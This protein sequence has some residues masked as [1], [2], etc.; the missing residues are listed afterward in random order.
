MDIPTCCWTRPISFELRDSPKPSGLSLAVLR[1]IPLKTIF[2]LWKLSRKAKQEGKETFSFSPMKDGYY[3]GISIG[4]MGAGTIGRSYRGDFIRWQLYPGKRRYQTLYANQFSIFIRNSQKTF[5]NVL[6]PNQPERNQLAA[7]KW[8]LSSNIGTYY[9]LYPRAW[10]KYERFPNF[11]NVSLICS[12][13]TP[14]IPHNYKDSS[15]P[16]G[17][18]NWE[19]ENKEKDPIQISLLLTWQNGDGSENDLKGSHFNSYKKYETIEGVLMTYNLPADQN[20]PASFFIGTQADSNVSITYHSTFDSSGDGSDI[21]EKFSQNGRLQNLDNSTPS[22]KGKSIAGA[23]CVSA[24]LKPGEQIHIPFVVSWDIPIMTFGEGRQW[25]KRYTKYFGTD[26]KN[27]VNIA[28]YALERRLEWNKKI[29]EWQNSI[30]NNDIIPLWIKTALF[31]ELYYLADGLTAWEHGEVGRRPQPDSY[32]GHWAYLECPDYPMYNTYDVHFYSSF[33]LAILFPEIQ[34]SITRDFAQAVL[35]ENTESLTMLFDGKK[36]SRKPL[37]VVPHDLGLPSEDPWIKVNSY[38]MHDIA[39]WKDL[40]S[41]FVLQVYRDSL[42]DDDRLSFIQS[43]WPAVVMAIEHLEQFDKD[44]NGLIE[45]GGFADQ[46][47]DVWKLKGVSAYCG[48]LWI[49]ALAAAIKMAETIGDEE[50]YNQYK[51][52]FNKAK[53][54]FDKILWNGDYYKLDTQRKNTQVIM[55]DQL[56]GQWW[57][58]ACDLEEALLPDDNVKKALGTIH[59]YNVRTFGEEKLGAVNGMLFSGKIDKR[60][61]QSQEVW[62]G[63]TYGLAALMLHE[64][65]DEM[66]FSTAYGAY[67]MTYERG[68]WFRTPEAW[69]KDGR[70]RASQYMRPL[71]I[72]AICWALKHRS[73][74]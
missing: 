55:S 53:L 20:G 1:S 27:A 25:Y 46:T 72:W 49:T 3:Q 41:K 74:S 48:G 63:T 14:M 70:Y 35:T 28:K 8:K 10:T 40:N 45:N 13:I 51:E 36:V 16:C 17:L 18:F 39:K 43:N 44:G 38:S 12:Q 60:G 2:K 50:R 52:T 21:W 62:S 33:A 22:N 29:E 26:G 4:G 47:Y 30:I 73:K 23:I 56:C 5:S 71:A 67:H 64:H 65:L 69:N 57:A 32:N 31:N 9:A 37:G 66:A 34:K 7:W 24:K 58:R 59:K 6:F 42:L 54:N 68:F 19:I 61:L 11:P 15:L